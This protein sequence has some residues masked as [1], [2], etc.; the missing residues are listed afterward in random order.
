MDDDR[1]DAIVVGPD[2]PGSPR[3]R[4]WRP[5]GSRWSCWSAAS[6]RGQER[7]GRDPLPGADRGDGAGIRGR[8]TAGA[9]NRRAALPAADGRRDDGRD[10]P[11]AALRRAPV[12]R[13][14][15][16]ARPVRSLVRQQGRKRP[17]RRSTRSS[18]WSICSG[19]M[20]PSSA[21]RPAMRR[22]SCWRAASSSP[23]ARTRCWRRRSGCTGSGSRSSRRWW[24]RS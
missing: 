18:P 20:A 4:R 3:R 7:L 11:L 12:Q 19:R 13:L 23:T 22:V 16:A 5:P 1:F 17:G 14:H 2:R 24:P 8:S 9:S 21:S 10:L 15:R 6:F